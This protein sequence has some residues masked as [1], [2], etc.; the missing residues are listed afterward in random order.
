MGRHHPVAAID[1]RVVER[2]PVNAGFQIVGDDK[3]RH[4]AKKTEH[5]DMG[6]DPVRQFLRPGRLGVSV[7]GGAK[8]GDEDL[9]FTHNPGARS[10]IMI[11]LPE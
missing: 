1:L 3:P 9:R 2:G 7:I 8:D 6:L 11:F 10:T 5:A 4:P